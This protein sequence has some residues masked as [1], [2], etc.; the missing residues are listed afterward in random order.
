VYLATADGI[1]VIEHDGKVK[2][3]PVRPTD[4]NP[5]AR[6]WGKPGVIHDFD[7]DGKADM[8]TGS[9]TDYSV[10]L[11]TSTA[12]PK[13]SAPVVDQSGLATGTAF[14]FLGDG[15]ADA[16]YADETQIYVYEGST[17]KLELSSPRSSGT[18]IEYPVVADVDND[19]SAEIV[20]VSN[21]L[22][23]GAGPT[24]TVL[25]DAQDRWI[26]S[27]RIWNQHAYHVTNVRED[28]TIPKTPK[29]NFQLLNTFRT[30]SQI[31]KSGDCD[32]NVPK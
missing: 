2:F 32:P 20:V 30:N 5:S 21:Y 28:G 14:D 29:K 4:P 3:G 31:G 24:V 12:T 9:C 17:G 1:S 18:L 15:V 11:L 16:I 10:Y 6:C 26:Q 7:G 27:R 23:G 25:K 22:L 19:G 8:A 13:W